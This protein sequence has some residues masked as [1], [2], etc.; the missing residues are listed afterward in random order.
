MVVSLVIL[1]RFIE[2]AGPWL[3][4]AS[5]QIVTQLMSICQYFCEYSDRH[6]KV[7]RSDAKVRATRL[8]GSGMKVCSILSSRVLAVAVLCALVLNAAPS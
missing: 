6:V 4:R 2:C 8:K 7:L 3:T 5:P 1:D